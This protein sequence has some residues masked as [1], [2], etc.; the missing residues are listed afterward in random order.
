MG[1]PTTSTPKARSRTMARIT[2]SC[3]QSFSPKMATCGRVRLKSL[4]T[5]VATPRKWP[6]RLAPQS[7]WLDP[8]DVHPGLVVGREHQGRVGRRQHQVDAGLGAGGQVA[9]QVARIAREVLGRAELGRVDEDGG[10]RQPAPAPASARRRAS[11]SSEWW[12]SCR[13]PMVGTSAR[14]WPSSRAAWQRACQA[15]GSVTSCGPA[16]ESA[17]PSLH[18]GADDAGQLLGA[19]PRAPAP[20]GRRRSGSCA[21]RPG[22]RRAFTSST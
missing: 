18:R 2:A 10:E 9:G 13:K 8:L 1:I 3:C 4:A 15:A 12:P 19:A 6:G 20:A 17:S 7:P 22:R 11:R 16:R 14:R 5:T 21:R